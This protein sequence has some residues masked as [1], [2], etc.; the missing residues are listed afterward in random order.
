MEKDTVLLDVKT[1]NELRDF[2]KN[3]TSGLVYRQSYGLYS[4]KPQ[5]IE[6]SEALEEMSSIIKEQEKTIDDKNDEI[7]EL[8]I[9]LNQSDTNN[10]SEISWW[11]LIILKIKSY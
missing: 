11:K 2:K 7:I 8:N 10:L 9:K 5:Y 1:Y 4:Y 3:T 6:S